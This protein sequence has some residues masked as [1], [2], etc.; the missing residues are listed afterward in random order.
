MS[1]ELMETVDME[2]LFELADGKKY[3]QLKEILL[4]LNAVDIASFIEEL[5]SERTVVVFRMLPKEVATD[6]FAEL[7]VE[8]ETHIINSITDQELGDI[9]DDLYVDDAVCLLYTSPSPR[10]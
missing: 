4:E 5:D 1:N 7:P 6:V 3:R 10:D 9:M 2:K 8:K